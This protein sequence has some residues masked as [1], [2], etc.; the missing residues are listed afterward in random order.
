MAT[1]PPGT[2]FY[3]PQAKPLSTFGVPM[4]GAYY[5]F[6]LTTT[7]TAANVYA[8]GALTTPLSQT[9]G[10]AQPS[11]TADANGRFNPI[12]LN[13]ATTYRVQ[14]F[15]SSG[16]K[17]EDVDPYVPSASLNAF[18]STV[19][20]GTMSLTDGVNSTTVN[21]QYSAPPG[22]NVT[23]QVSGGV[24]TSGST[25]LVLNGLPTPA[26]PTTGNSYIPVAIE[27][28]SAFSTGIVEITTSG[29]LTLWPN[30]AG[31]STWTS[32]GTKGI[33]VGFTVTYPLS[34]IVEH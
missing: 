24:I 12:Y 1:P 29:T 26:T 20:S 15:N 18:A 3:D 19:G 31:P 9:P 16:V 27:N 17:L 21:Y 32:G 34:G 7:L 5:L 6:F 30:S 25:T 2:L 13:P 33:P 8:D 4:P 10:Q 23:L 11:T 28:N 14:L 22:G